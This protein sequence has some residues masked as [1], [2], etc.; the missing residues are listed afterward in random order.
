MEANEILEGKR[1]IAEYME[2][3]PRPYSGGKYA[4]TDTPVFHSDGNYEVVMD[5]IAV[6]SKYD[7]SWD[8]LIPVIKKIEKEE[9]NGNSIYLYLMGSPLTSDISYI[10]KRVV[11]FITWFN[12]IKQYK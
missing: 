10:F 8:W 2:L 12:T 9:R 11:E 7:T 4:F 1:L 6:Y 3:V 5:D